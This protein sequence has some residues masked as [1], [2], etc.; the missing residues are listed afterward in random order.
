VGEEQPASA[1]GGDAPVKVE[2]G[3]GLFLALLV[4]VGSVVL[5]VMVMAGQALLALLGLGG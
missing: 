1:H 4:V 5:V 3:C 2:V